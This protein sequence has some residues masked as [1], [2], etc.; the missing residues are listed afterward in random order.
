MQQVLRLYFRTGH[1]QLPKMVSMKL[2]MR[3]WQSIV[4]RFQRQAKLPTRIQLEIIRI[5]RVHR[6]R[7]NKGE[8]YKFDVIFQ[9]C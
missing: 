2:Q 3:F 4:V 5:E 1:K 9:A 8:R 7:M 6:I